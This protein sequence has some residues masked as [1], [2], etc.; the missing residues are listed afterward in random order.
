MIDVFGQTIE[1]IMQEFPEAEWLARCRAAL[2]DAD[3]DEII[4]AI[5][6]YAGG[7]SIEVQD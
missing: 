5:E 1:K 7:D 4:A 2:P 3:D 6:I